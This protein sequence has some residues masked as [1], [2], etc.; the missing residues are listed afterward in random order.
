M[1]RILIVDDERGS[2]ESL[3]AIFERT[4]DLVLADNAAAALD[5]LARQRFDLVLLDVMMPEKDGVTLLKEAQESALGAPFIMVSASHNVKPVVEAMRSGACDFVTKPFDVQEIRRAVA[6]ALETSA[7]RRQVEVLQRDLA[8]QFPVDEMAGRDPA[9]LAL[10]DMTAR[11]AESEATVLITGES[12]TG[13]EL[14]ARR[15]HALSARRAEPFV[16]VHCGALPETLIESELFGHE[17]G[18]FTGAD[19]RKPGRFDLAGAGTL[20]LDEVGET[21][22]ATQVKLLRVLQEREYMR[23]GGTQTIRTNARIVAASNRDLRAEM[24]AGRFREDLFYRLNVL[25]LHAPALR[26][27]PDD[28]PLLAQHYLGTFRAS[29]NTAASGFTAVAEQALRAYPWPGNVRELRNLVERMVVLHPRTATL[30]LAHL[31]AELRPPGT[32]APS[33]P[34]APA[35]G[36]DEAVKSF[37]RGLVENALR[38]AGGVQT[39]A[40]QLLGTTRR[41]LKYRMDQLGIHP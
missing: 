6:R 4:Y 32:P 41:I 18:A 22:P 24:Q 8:R 11:A 29:L 23:V 13:K 16:A 31:P 36:L 9:F 26:D 39:K 33:A 2:R 20:F 37:E 21:P 14:V 25:P 27:R 5:L 30:D 12:G 28:I 3:R 19:K 40:A 38:E 17:K 7:L 34:A 35:A 1:K 15:L 10:L